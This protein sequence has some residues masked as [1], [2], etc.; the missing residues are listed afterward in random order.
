MLIRE[1]SPIVLRDSSFVFN[2]AWKIKNIRHV[3]SDKMLELCFCQMHY[4]IEN[5]RKTNNDNCGAYFLFCLKTY[6]SSAVSEKICW[7][8]ILKNKLKHILFQ[9]LYS[10]TIFV[11]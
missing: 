8:S 6:C 1:N 10:A 5:K 2:H 11:I 3:N 7:N 4:E 9:I